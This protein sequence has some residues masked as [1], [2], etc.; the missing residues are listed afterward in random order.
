[1]SVAP[2]PPG[3]FIMK[4]LT[5]FIEFSVSYIIFLT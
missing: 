1:M 3:L 2:G 5:I 4:C